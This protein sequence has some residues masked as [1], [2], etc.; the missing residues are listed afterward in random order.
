MSSRDNK[1]ASNPEH[2]RDVGRAAKLGVW[3]GCL[4][5]ALLGSQAAFM[6]Q[7][8]PVAGAVLF[9]FVGM[10][11]GAIAGAFIDDDE[12]KISTF[13]TN[14]GAIIGTITLAII[15]Y[16]QG[17]TTSGWLIAGLIGCV[18]G[19]VLGALCFDLARKSMI[20]VLLI[21]MILALPTPVGKWFRGHVL[22]MY[23]SAADTQSEQSSES[24]YRSI[25]DR[26]ILSLD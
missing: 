26:R 23:Q 21:I 2:S 22:K 5:G 1:A 17:A 20:I 25:E 10:I 18:I 19:G 3:R 11:V 12:G 6:L 4:A 24:T 8:H 14:I 16:K 7:I 15:A 13:F 9:G